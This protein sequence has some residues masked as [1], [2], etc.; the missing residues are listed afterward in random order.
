MATKPPTRSV[1]KD[2][3]STNRD[4]DFDDF[5]E[6]NFRESPV[7]GPPHWIVRSQ[8]SHTGAPSAAIPRWIVMWSLIKR[9]NHS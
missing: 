5:L 2:D 7:G 9:E 1:F 8:S 6:K 4:R 3:S